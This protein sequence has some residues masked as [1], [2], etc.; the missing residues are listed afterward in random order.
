[1]HGIGG[2]QEGVARGAEGVNRRKGPIRVQ[3]LGP[4]HLAWLSIHSTRNPV[5]L[6]KM[7]AEGFEI[8]HLDGNHK[9]NEP[10]NLILVEYIDHRRLHGKN[11]HEFSA[12]VREER[13][14][15]IEEN[16]RLGELAYEARIT[17]KSWGDVY[18]S[19]PDEFKGNDPAMV[20]RLYAAA[21]GRPWPFSKGRQK[22][23]RNN[24]VP[25]M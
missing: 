1:M 17:A 16:L 20:A 12:D 22:S 3:G 18:H 2:T 15:D 21:S 7:L 11:H 24:I 13:K 14:R 8:H 9:N 6:L 23:F 4:H 10:R 5:W 19:M 25:K